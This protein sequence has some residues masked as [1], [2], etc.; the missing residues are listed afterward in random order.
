[1]IP[2]MTIRCKAFVVN[3]IIRNR[4]DE[5]NSKFS[6]RVFQLYL[7]AFTLCRTFPFDR[8]FLVS[9]YRLLLVRPQKL[10]GGWNEK[11]TYENITVNDCAD[12]CCFDYYDLPWLFRAYHRNVV[13][14]TQRR[15][16]N[17]HNLP[18]CW[19]AYHRNVVR[20]TQR[21][22]LNYHNLPG[23]GWENHRQ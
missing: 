23:C 21:R 4:L 5:K 8:F 2:G 22:W 10:K 6:G 16:L 20:A 14:T 12:C 11:F 7:V 13:R 3:K 17:Y 9:G 18:G 1:M 19:R 15:W